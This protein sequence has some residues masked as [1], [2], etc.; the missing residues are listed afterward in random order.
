MRKGNRSTSSST[1]K[2]DSTNIQSSD[3][4]LTN[5]F[6]STNRFNSTNQFNSSNQ[7][8]RTVA[9]GPVTTNT[10]SAKPVRVTTL[11]NSDDP[12]D[13]YVIPT[14]ELF[15]AYAPNPQTLPVVN[16]RLPFNELPTKHEE[17][18]CYKV[19]EYC[20]KYYKIISTDDIQ[21]IEIFYDD[22]SCVNEAIVKYAKTHHE[23]PSSEYVDNVL[24]K[25]SYI[26]DKILI[27]TSQSTPII[28]Y[29]DM[30]TADEMEEEAAQKGEDINIDGWFVSNE[31]DY[32]VDFVSA[33]VEEAESLRLQVD[34]LIKAGKET[35]LDS[36]FEEEEA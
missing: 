23:A 32:F 30:C 33:I 16:R 9:F 14:G 22:R 24:M 7:T 31:D 1:K 18:A 13:N 5:Q 27:H 25:N 10:K 11:F 2:P 12:K 34:G 8:T 36:L 15:K 35:S 17:W 28:V 3:T 20:K 29:Y 19:W 6:N 26:T 4:R 21:S